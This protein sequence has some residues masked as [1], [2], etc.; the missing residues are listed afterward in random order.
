MPVPVSAL[1]HFG[2]AFT[3]LEA[4][5]A[6]DAQAEIL[7]AEVELMPLRP[8]LT[9]TELL[10]ISAAIATTLKRCGDLRGAASRLERVC[11]M[12]LSLSPGALETVGD[13]CDLAECYEELGQLAEAREAIRKA[14]AICERRFPKYA[15]ALDARLDAVQ[16]RIAAEHPRG[17]S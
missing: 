11:E 16:A 4:G 13:F 5:R 6:A 17:R 1:R 14:R 15:A 10:M 2:A 3:H 8:L 7:Q 9:P 12:A